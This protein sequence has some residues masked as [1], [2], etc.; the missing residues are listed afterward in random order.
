MKG[1]TSLNGPPDLGEKLTRAEYEAR[2]IE[3]H[4]SGSPMP[5]ESQEL[6]IRRAELNLLIDHKLG[7]ELSRE[8]R[9]A[10][11]MEQ[12]RVDRHLPW[13]VLVG[14][15]KHPTHPSDEIAKSQVRAF[16]NILTPVE[17]CALFDLSG[18]DLNRFLR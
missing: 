10:L 14:F 2:V 9:D 5:S 4:A 1:K 7:A 8:R 13:R 12:A 15:L 18:E 11:W 17:L 3:L 6:A 16:A